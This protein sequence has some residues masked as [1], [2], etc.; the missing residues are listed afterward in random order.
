MDPLNSIEHGTKQF[1]ASTI[2]WRRVLRIT[3]GLAVAA[4]AVII[5]QR[6]L[7][8]PLTVERIDDAEWGFKTN[9]SRTSGIRCYWH[10]RSSRNS[11]DPYDVVYF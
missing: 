11:G 2:P 1:R 9:P 7:V 8:P 6:Y 5:T 10:R 4:L 3:P